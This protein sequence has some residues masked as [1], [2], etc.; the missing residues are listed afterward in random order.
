MIILFSEWLQYPKEPHW[1]SGSHA[2]SQHGSLCK[3]ECGWILLV[4]RDLSGTPLA[5]TDGS[6]MTTACSAEGSGRVTCSAVTP[7]GRIYFDSAGLC[8][9]S[10]KCSAPIWVL[11]PLVTVFWCIFMY[12]GVHAYVWCAHTHVWRSGQPQVFLF[13]YQ[14]FYPFT[15]KVLVYLSSSQKCRLYSVCSLSAPARPCTP[16]PSFCSCAHLAVLW[17]SFLLLGALSCKSVFMLIFLCIFQRLINHN[18]AI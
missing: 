13:S 9:C 11:G 1:G 17:R 4:G 8:A 10:S 2:C 18:K 14:L 15:K 7:Q 16:H 6:G 5:L 3:S 12:M